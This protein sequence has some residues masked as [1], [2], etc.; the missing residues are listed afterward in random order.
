MKS[1]SEWLDN[2]QFVW[3]FRWYE[4]A[5]DIEGDPPLKPERSGDVENVLIRQYNRQKEAVQPA[6]PLQHESVQ[7]RDGADG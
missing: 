3:L 7:G 6:Q 2:S 5:C 1:P 4:M